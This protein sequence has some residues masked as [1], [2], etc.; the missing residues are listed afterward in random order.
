MLRCGSDNEDHGPCG[1]VHGKTG[2]KNLGWCDH[3]SRV[4]GV[5]SGQRNDNNV[6][7]TESFED[8]EMF[9]LGA[10]TRTFFYTE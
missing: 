8:A 2:Q 4:H 3:G 5:T 10:G 9:F 6:A 7:L 1:R